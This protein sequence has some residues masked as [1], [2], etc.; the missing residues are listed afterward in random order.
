M[1]KLDARI[2]FLEDILTSEMVGDSQRDDL[3]E[4]VSKLKGGLIIVHPGGR[5][6]LEVSECRD[7]IE[8]AVC[9]VHAALKHGFVAGGGSALIHASSGLKQLQ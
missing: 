4:R 9:A 5:T 7:R 2:A 8:D 3:S 6:E 1:S